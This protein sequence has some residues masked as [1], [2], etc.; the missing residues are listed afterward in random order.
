MTFRL[1]NV[2]ASQP[3]WEMFEKHGVN[4]LSGEAGTSVRR[5]IRF[6]SDLPVKEEYSDYVR[7]AIEQWECD[8]LR[9]R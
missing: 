5:R 2:V 9:I 4:A 7:R 6:D 1:G 3:Q 8:R